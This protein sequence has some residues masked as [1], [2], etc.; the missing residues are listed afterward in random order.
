FSPL[1]GRTIRLYC[2][3]VDEMTEASPLLFALRD[4]LDVFRFTF[5]GSFAPDAPAGHML[6]E[7]NS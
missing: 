4:F 2:V 1:P 7:T 5:D 3:F 6:F